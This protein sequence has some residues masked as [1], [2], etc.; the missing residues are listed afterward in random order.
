MSS[1]DLFIFG[2]R[3]NQA[4]IRRARLTYPRATGFCL[5]SD[6]EVPSGGIVGLYLPQIRVCTG[7]KVTW[8]GSGEFAVKLSIELGDERLE[9]MPGHCYYYLRNPYANYADWLEYRARE[10]LE[11][12]MRVNLWP[13]S[14]DEIE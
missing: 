14:L 4:V 8:I 9:R 5:I 10:T 3:R 7:G 2:V 13:L 12:R 6:N 1:A 11:R